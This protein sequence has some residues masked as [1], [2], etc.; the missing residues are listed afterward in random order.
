MLKF[1]KPVGRAVWIPALSR[2]IAEA[3]EKLRV[4]AYIEKRI[5]SGVLK[6]VAES[7]EKAT[8]NR[9]TEIKSEES[10]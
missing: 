10:K 4:T 7:A 3:G 2:K 1:L 5:R 6:I 8:K 9:K